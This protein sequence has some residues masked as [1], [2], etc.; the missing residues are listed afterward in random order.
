MD[1]GYGRDRST[2]GYLV[3]LYVSTSCQLLNAQSVDRLNYGIFYDTIGSAYVEHFCFIYDLLILLPNVTTTFIPEVLPTC[4]Y[5]KSFS[6]NQF[7]YGWMQLQPVASTLNYINAIRCSSGL[8]T[9]ITV[10]H[11]YDRDIHSDITK[12]IQQ[13]HSTLPEDMLLIKST[14]NERA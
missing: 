8:R 10:L 11:D 7:L 6:V 4:L 12:L 13:I 14:R 5:N 1:G 3:I 2:N 9:L